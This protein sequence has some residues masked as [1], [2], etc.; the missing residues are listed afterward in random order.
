MGTG[1]FAVGLATLVVAYAAT[2]FIVERIYH[3]GRANLLTIR[4]V[5]F[6]MEAVVRL[7]EAVL[8]RIRALPL[9]QA[10]RRLALRTR[11][12]LARLRQRLRR[13]FA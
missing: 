10:A 11:I 3:A 9:F 5:A 7:R 4:W 2:F 8:D 1:R 13:L 6:V 12:R